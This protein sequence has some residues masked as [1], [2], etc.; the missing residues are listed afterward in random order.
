MATWLL[1]VRTAEGGALGPERQ[2]EVS[3]P[4]LADAIQDAPLGFQPQDMAEAVT[5]VRWRAD[6]VPDV[7]VAPKEKGQADG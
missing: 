1:T 3:G 5:D 2:V 6:R 7:A 4:T